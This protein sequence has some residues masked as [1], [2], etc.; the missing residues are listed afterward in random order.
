MSK[1]INNNE[2]INMTLREYFEKYQNVSLRKLA[3]STNSTYGLMLKYSKQPIVGETYDPDAINWTAVENYLTKRGVVLSDL[4]WEALNEET[5]RKGSTLCKDMDQFTTGK[6]VYLRK[7]NVTPYEIVYKTAT[8]IVLM[9]E[10][11][12]EPIA[13]SN[14]TF[15]INGPVFEPRTIKATEEKVEEA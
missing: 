15:L 13:W 11:T 1:K 5:A 12:S 2:A 4:D 9:K 6:K 3:V 7:D 10:G 14:N 8:H